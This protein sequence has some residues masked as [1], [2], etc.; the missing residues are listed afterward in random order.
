M[1]EARVELMSLR[2]ACRSRFSR[3]CRLMTLTDNLASALAYERG[4]A[5]NRGLRT[6]VARASSYQIACTVLWLHRYVVSEVNPYDFD[7]RAANRGEVFP[8]T[9]WHHV[10]FNPSTFEEVFPWSSRRHKEG[11]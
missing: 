4:R 5:R 10:W 3:H 1:L 2:H 9:F 6:L 11:R 8:K 7:S